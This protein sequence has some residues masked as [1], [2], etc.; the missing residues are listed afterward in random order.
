MLNIPWRSYPQRH[1]RREQV[2]G[3]IHPNFSFPRQFIS[4]NWLTQHTGIQPLDILRLDQF[5]VI[6]FSTKIIEQKRKASYMGNKYE[7]LASLQMKMLSWKKYLEVF[8]KAITNLL[9]FGEKKQNFCVR[10]AFKKKLLRRRHWSIWE[11]GG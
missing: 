4:I 10:D 3:L 11:G 9:N 5:S 6:S 8:L 7:K 2:R 1:S